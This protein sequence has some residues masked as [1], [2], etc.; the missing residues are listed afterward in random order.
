MKYSKFDYDYSTGK[1]YLMI[2]PE[3]VEI[4][5][6]I[7]LRGSGPVYDK[8]R[9]TR[10]YMDYVGIPLTIKSKNFEIFRVKENAFAYTFE[11]IDPE[12]GNVKGLRERHL[13]DSNLFE[14]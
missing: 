5:D 13:L 14:L 1:K 10:W 2:E 6:I 11:K 9:T 3:D 7:F 8:Y 4:G 12:M